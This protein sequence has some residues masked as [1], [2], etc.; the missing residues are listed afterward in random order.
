MGV[1]VAL[2]SHAAPQPAGRVAGYQ[3]RTEG[4]QA[5]AEHRAPHGPEGLRGAAHGEV[6]GYRK[7][8]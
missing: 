1:S 8:S 2:R 3:A 6:W 4:L 5:A 7:G